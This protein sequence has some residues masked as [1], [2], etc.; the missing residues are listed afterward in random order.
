MTVLGTLLVAQLTEIIGSCRHFRVKPDCCVT[1]STKED[2]TRRLVN[3]VVMGQNNRLVPRSEDRDLT[4]DG[5]SKAIF[6]FM[7]PGS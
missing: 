6:G 5:V 7:V 1:F 4:V 2:E 3:F